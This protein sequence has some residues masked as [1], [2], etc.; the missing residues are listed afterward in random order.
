MSTRNDLVTHDAGAV[1]DPAT[2]A[3]APARP[4]YAEA[5]TALQQSDADAALAR[6]IQVLVQD[7]SYDAD[8]ARRACLA[9]FATLGEG[10]PVVKQHRPVFNRSL[11]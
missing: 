1:R 9:I 7:R 5:L 10:H 3:E 4:L 2:L 11:Y 8:G 6:F